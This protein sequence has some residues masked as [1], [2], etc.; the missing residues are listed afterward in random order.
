MICCT[1]LQIK[2][3]SLDIE[4][5]FTVKFCK[6]LTKPIDIS[7]CNP[8]IWRSNTVINILRYCQRFTVINIFSLFLLY[9][10]LIISL[11]SLA[12]KYFQYFLFK[13]FIN[14]K[15]T[16][17]RILILFKNKF[18]SINY[19]KSFFLILWQKVNE[20]HFVYYFS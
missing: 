19:L 5:L 11:T 4:I 9:S 3:I 12:G 7:W 15:W 2:S 20:Q 1:V 14:C 8:D 16:Y 13:T 18:L 6:A 10:I 17:P